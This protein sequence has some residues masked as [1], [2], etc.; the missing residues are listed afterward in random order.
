MSRIGAAVPGT[1]L[2]SS[3]CISA[4]AAPPGRLVNSKASSEPCLPPGEKKT[5][6]FTVGKDE[7]SFWSPEAKAWVEESEEFDVWVGGDS[8]AS[9]HAR[10]RVAG[11]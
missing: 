3:I 7:L 11:K 2:S 10:S 5:V 1:K 8:T 9:L 6:R 4:R